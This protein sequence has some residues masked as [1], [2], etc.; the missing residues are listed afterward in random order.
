MSVGKPTAD[1]HSMLGVEDVRR[2]RVVN[3]D[4]VLEISSDL[5]EILDVVALVVVTALAEEPMMDDFV[6]IKLIQQRVAVLQLPL[7]Q[8]LAVLRIGRLTLE[9]DAV[10]TTTS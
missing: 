5:R 2:R 8:T 10:K 3:D 4:G 6:N 7:A 9:T 1:G